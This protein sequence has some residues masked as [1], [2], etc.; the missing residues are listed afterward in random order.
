MFIWDDFFLDKETICILDL[1]LQ[2]IST[3]SPMK[4]QIEQNMHLL[5]VFFFFSKY[6]M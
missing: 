6:I 1:V 3:S 4:L 2:N 5:N